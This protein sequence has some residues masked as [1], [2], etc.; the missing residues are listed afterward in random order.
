MNGWPWSDMNEAAFGV[1]LDMSRAG[2]GAGMTQGLHTLVQPYSHWISAHAQ[3]M[4]TS[5]A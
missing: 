4:L 2:R 5:A 3:A 1:R